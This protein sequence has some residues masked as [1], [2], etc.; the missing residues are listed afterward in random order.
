MSLGKESKQGNIM[1]ILL[2]FLLGGRFFQ[3]LASH[4]F[5]KQQNVLLFF[6]QIFIYFKPKAHS[7]LSLSSSIHPS[8]QLSTQLASFHNEIGIK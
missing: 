5:P 4:V 1:F 7:H 2:A 8:T 6:Q 3:S